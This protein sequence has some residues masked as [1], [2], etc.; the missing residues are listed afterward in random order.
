[1]DPLHLMGVFVAVVDAGGFAA[2]AR[3][4]GM[5]APAVTRAINE[6]ESQLAVRLLTR[7]TRV[8]RVTEA[9]TRYAEDGRRILAAVQEA[10]QSARGVHGAPR[11]R[12]V[13]TAPA[14]FGALFVTPIVTD[15]LQRYPDTSASCWFVD[16]V[17]NL[18]EEG[19]DVAVRIGELPDSSLQAV[20]V[21]HVRRLICASPGY[22]AAR[23]TPRSVDDL[24]RHSL[25][26]AN[27]VTPVVEWPLREAGS[28]RGVKLE[29]RLTL[30]ATDAA[31]TAALAGFG[32]TQLLSYQVQGPL[33]DGTLVPVL[34]DL[35]PEPLPVHVVHHEG[36]HAA[37]KVRAFLDLAID[38]LRA[39]PALQQP[40]R[41]RAQDG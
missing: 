18:L 15:Y 23:G 11:G 28:Q 5:S 40:G 29:P 19:I 41:D 9:G 7:T 27:R 31:R 13:V 17:V 14:M 8:V 16:R 3:K 6:L 37:Q 34:E 4:L 36:R 39:N 32:L 20:C 38:A 24:A 2:A 21:G 10:G 26:A 35:E 30:S 22:L 1:M 25:V 33:R 12:L